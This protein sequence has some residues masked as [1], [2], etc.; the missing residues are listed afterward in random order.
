LVLLIGPKLDMMPVALFRQKKL[1]M[2]GKLFLTS[3]Q[4][5]QGVKLSAASI[6]FGSQN[7]TQSLGFFLPGTISARDLDQHIGI[8]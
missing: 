6:C 7:S 3:A 2:L 1:K 8:G 5:H 4:R